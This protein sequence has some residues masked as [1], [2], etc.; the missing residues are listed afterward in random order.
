M[1]VVGVLNETTPGI[2]TPID[3][4]VILIAEPNDKNYCYQ[5]IR[6]IP[7]FSLTHNNLDICFHFVAGFATPL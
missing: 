4:A 6:W 1:F 5:N 7:K 3:L 2:G